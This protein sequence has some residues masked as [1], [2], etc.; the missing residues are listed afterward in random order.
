MYCHLQTFV[1]SLIY[2]NVYLNG[3]NTIEKRLTLVL[4]IR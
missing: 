1:I 2:F 4:V 3:T